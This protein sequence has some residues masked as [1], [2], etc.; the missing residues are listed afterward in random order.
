MGAPFNTTGVNQNMGALNM[1][2]DLRMG[3][4]TQ[5]AVVRTFTGRLRCHVAEFRVERLTNMVN[6]NPFVWGDLTTRLK[7][8]LRPLFVPQVPHHDRTQVA[9]RF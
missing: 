5:P 7:Q 6:Q 4:P 3:Q 2:P 9:G 1:A 8:D